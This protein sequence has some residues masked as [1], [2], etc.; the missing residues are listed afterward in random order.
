M[1]V[2]AHE[3]VAL[4][5]MCPG[6]E[7]LCVCNIQPNRRCHTAVQ[8]SEPLCT[9]AQCKEALDGPTSH[10]HVS[11]S[12]CNLEIPLNFSWDLFLTTW[13]SYDSHTIH[14]FKVYTS[15]HSQSCAPVTTFNFRIFPSPHSHPFPCPGLHPGT[16]H[17]LFCS[18]SL[19]V[20]LFWTFHV[21]GVHISCK[22]GVL[23]LASFT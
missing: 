12:D 2:A 10:P 11:I 7:L 16:R 9:M 8:V 13:L 17:L 18:P 22:C 14:T 15:V 23:W 3:H 5:I 20:S 19:Y 21:N 1:F 4:R 6:V